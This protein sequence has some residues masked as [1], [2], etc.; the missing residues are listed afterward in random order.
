MRPT[1]PVVYR[2]AGCSAV[3]PNSKILGRESS[4]MVDSFPMALRFPYGA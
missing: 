3:M 1:S 2:Y 4:N